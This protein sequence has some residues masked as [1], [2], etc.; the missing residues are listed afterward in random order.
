MAD[1]SAVQIRKFTTLFNAYDY[2]KNQY[3]TRDDCLTFAQRVSTVFGWEKQ[4]P[5][6][7]ETR[8]AVLEHS[9]EQLFNRL[10]DA[11]DRDH[12]NQVSLAEYLAWFK[13]QAMECK[14]MGRAAPWIKQSS[15]EIWQLFDADGTGS[16][17]LSE[18]GKMLAVMGSSADPASVFAKLDQDG[19]GKLTLP[20]VERLLLEFICSDDPD[21]PGNLF[22]C[23]RF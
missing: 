18:Y 5:N 13:R 17:D 10:L 20:D 14:N 21:A 3:L 16:I 4:D 1:L 7:H 19:D 11:S 15:K 23:G 22:Y 8:L 6:V 12:D 9:R 2:S